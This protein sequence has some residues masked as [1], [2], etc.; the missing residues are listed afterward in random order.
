MNDVDIK[1]VTHIHFVGI[2]GVAMAALAI[3]CKQRG[4]RVSG[5]DISEEFPTDEML[6]RAGIIVQQSFDPKNIHTR[7]KPN[8]VIYT[9]AHG[10]QEN[11][12]VVEAERLGIPVLVHG[13][14]LGFFMQDKRQLSVAGSHGKTTTSAMIATIMSHAGLDPSYAIGCGEIFG[15]GVP[16][17]FGS[18]EWFVAEAD[19]YITDKDHDSTPRFLWQHPDILVVTNIDFD[20]PDAYASLADV[21]DAFVRL[22]RNLV[23]IKTTI[24][25]ADDRA[26]DVLRRTGVVISNGFSSQADYHIVDI[27]YGSMRTFYAIVYKGREIGK[28]SLKV[29][30]KHNALNAT[31]ASVACM[32]LGLSWDEIG[33]GLLGFGGTK[34][35]F[36]KIGEVDGM[37][38]YDDYA[39]HPAE[40][41]ATLSSIKMWFPDKK[42]IV[43]FQSHTYSRTKALLS[44]FATSFAL[45]DTV[46]ITDIYASA[47]EQDTGDIN[48]PI[49]AAVVAKHHPH[50]F[51]T[52]G[53]EEVYEYLKLHRS[54]ENIVFFMGAGDIYHWGRKIFKKLRQ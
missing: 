29:P 44:E 42:C 41:A 22:Q 21:K 36:E 35:R 32:A 53:E 2:K 17:H 11:R 43:V 3:Y 23:G 39:H 7:P 8:L 37:V 50:V 25:N 18:G 31:A 52:K 49:F 47:R 38:F 48:G 28:F 5:S 40:I 10:G 9:G 19:E 51:Y 15:L 26:S 20:H 12:E 54:K 6:H 24:V 34:R 1:N 4:M 33:K 14:A 13:K 30:G 27:S 45:A 16:G 46:L